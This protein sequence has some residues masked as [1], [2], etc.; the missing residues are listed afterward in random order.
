MKFSNVNVNDIASLLKFL[1]EDFL[2]DE[3]YMDVCNLNLHD[4]DDLRELVKK[5]IVPGFLEMND[6]TQSYLRLV[7]LECMKREFDVGL[8]SERISSFFDFEDINFK[9]FIALINEEIEK[10]RS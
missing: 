7:L 1:D 10:A 8:V 2:D 5:V 4:R 3:V 6:A 9:L